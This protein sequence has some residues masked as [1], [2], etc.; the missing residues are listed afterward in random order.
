V[1]EDMQ[2]EIFPDDIWNLGEEACI[3]GCITAALPTNIVITNSRFSK[4]RRRSS[5]L[6][7]LANFK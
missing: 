6:A 2:G 3:A 4:E 5:G 1:V 7:R